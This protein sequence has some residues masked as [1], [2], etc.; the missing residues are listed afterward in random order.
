MSDPPQF[1]PLASADPSGLLMVGGRLEPDWLME[2][3]RR[4]IFPWPIV[5]RRRETLAWFS[6]DPRAVLELGVLHVSRRLRRRLRSGQFRITADQAFAGV[7]AGCARPRR[8][9]D[10]VWITPRLADAYVRLH[11]LGHAHS[12]DVWQAERLVGGLY[13]VGLGGYFAAESMFYRE[14]D[15]SKAALA[16]LVDR[17]RRRGY[18]LLDVQIITPHVARLGASEIPRGDFLRRLREAIDLPVAFGEPGE[19]DARRLGM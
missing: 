19:I 1:P 18:R 9:S 5:E 4:G 16:A 8:A 7:L 6:P 14:R 15:A 17:L 11:K 3:Y 10:G 12:I 13:G 2:A